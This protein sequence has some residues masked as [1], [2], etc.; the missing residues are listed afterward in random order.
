M[1]GTVRRPVDKFVSPYRVPYVRYLCRHSNCVDIL[2]I[3]ESEATAF[4]SSQA[5]EN[6]DRPNMN[7]LGYTHEEAHRLSV[8]YLEES[9]CTIREALLWSMRSKNRRVRSSLKQSTQHVLV[10]SIFLL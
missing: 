8:G 10:I 5:H 1:Q 9:S 6:E 4:V 7:L 2:G 3:P